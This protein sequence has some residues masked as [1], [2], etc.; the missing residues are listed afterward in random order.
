MNR[1]NFILYMLTSSLTLIFLLK[2]YKRIYHLLWT[3][4]ASYNLTFP[5][6]INFK[7]FIFPHGSQIE[8]S[9]EMIVL[10]GFFITTEGLLDQPCNTI[11]F[12]N[13][14][15][16]ENCKLIDAQCSLLI[17]SIKMPVIRNNQ[18]KTFYFPIYCQREWSWNCSN[19]PFI[20]YFHLSVQWPNVNFPR[21]V[22]VVWHNIHSSVI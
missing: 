6:T 9:C 20:S 12:M 22:W 2:N 13:S 5:V 16:I 14:Y 18:N 19:F 7:T 8:I 15:F 1:P 4:S 11:V 17:D 10:L 21:D 3:K